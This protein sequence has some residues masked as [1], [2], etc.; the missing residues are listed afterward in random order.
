VVVLYEPSRGDRKLTGWSQFL[1][2][3]RARSVKVHITSHRHTYD[4]SNARDW[5]TLADEGV[6]SAYESEQTSMRIRRDM[7]DAAARGIPH[8]RLAYGYM[9]RYDPDTRAVQQLPDPRTGPI[10]AEIITR[11]A[12]G[13][14]VTAI[15]RDRV[16]R[17]IPSP[18]GGERWARSTICRMV[19]EGACYIGKRRHNG[20]ALLDGNWPALVD[21]SVYW[22]AVAVL[23]DPARKTLADGRGGIRPGAAKW[24]LSF[25]ASC[26]KC[27]APL[28][29]TRRTR[30]GKVIPHYRCSSSAGGCAVC[31]VEFMDHC[32]TE[33]VFHWITNAPGVWEGLMAPDDSDASAARDELAAE[34]NRLDQFERE[35]IDGRIS[36][37][38]FARIA[39]GIEARIAE[40]EQL[41]VNRP[42]NPALRDLLAPGNRPDLLRRVWD[43]MPLTARRSVLR[44]LFAE[45]GYIR[46]APAA[47]HARALDPSRIKLRFPDLAA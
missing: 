34:R 27:G 42:T 3:C 22:R 4:L 13:D 25:I 46:L 45:P 37:D 12:G 11:I 40:L 18:T 30:G 24:L 14:S 1:D 6:S 31:P 35:A 29:V 33:A 5:R 23:S 21:E 39:R 32:V 17:G 26:A 36:P 38:S 28:S 7:A 41:S 44:T 15:Q 20:G 19:L 16:S 8:G 43:G 2:E 47:S 10:A 9:R